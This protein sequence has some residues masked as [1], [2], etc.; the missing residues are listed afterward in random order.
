M[1]YI[2]HPIFRDHFFDPEKPHRI[3]RVSKDKIYD[4][5]RNHVI[6]N[7]SVTENH[8]F[9]LKSIFKNQIVSLSEIISGAS[10]S[11]PLEVV[12]S[13]I[14]KHSADD[15]KIYLDI[16]K[17]KE[18]TSADYAENILSHYIAQK[19]YLLIMRSYN[20]RKRNGFI[21]NHSCS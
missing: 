13:G 18:S 15:G 19:Q 10:D 3:S 6:Q 4:T 1:V 8:N 2:Q 17:L 5:I 12:K 7:N 16:D 20:D 14:I 11:L 9:D 21:R